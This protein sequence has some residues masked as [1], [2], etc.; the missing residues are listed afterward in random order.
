MPQPIPRFVRFSLP[1]IR[2][3]LLGIALL[4]AG[5]PLFWLLGGIRWLAV[6]VFPVR[7]P[8]F[9]PINSVWIDAPSLPIS[10]HHGWWFGCGVSQSGT[11]NY[12]SLAGADGELA[13]EGEYLPCG[14][15]FPIEENNIQLVPPPDDSD[16][17]LFGEGNKGVIGFL[18]DGNRLLPVPAQ[19]KC[20]QVKARLVLHRS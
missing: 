4:I 5:L 1:S 9:M 18:A 10:W 19:D 17:W 7:C 15:G 13:Y 3:V 16:L 12:C 11:T 8:R 6:E 20:G 2:T 14:S